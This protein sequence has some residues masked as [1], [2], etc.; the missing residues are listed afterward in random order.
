MRDSKGREAGQDK[1]GVQMDLHQALTSFALYE[2]CL[3]VKTGIADLWRVRDSQQRDLVLKLYHSDDMGNEAPGV[4]LMQI[5]AQANP[6]PVPHLYHV[7]RNAIVMDFIEAGTLGQAMRDGHWAAD[8]ALATFAADLHNVPL[9]PVV[10][11]P[12]LSEWF[13]VLFQITFAPDCPDGTKRD[14][15][16]A[17][18]LARGLLQSQSNIRPLHG[19]LHHDNVFC[20]DFGHVAID[21][22]GV[23]GEPAYE[24]ANAMRNPKGCAARLY[25]KDLQINRLDI[26]ARHLSVDRTRLAQWAAAKCAWSMAL[27]AKG[28]QKADPEADLLSLLLNLADEA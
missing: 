10:G 20:S 16:R 23:L 25:D 19:D 8:E 14:M 24:L 7:T 12:A 2:P 9:P 1:A 15:R 4:A 28:T 17:S 3:L 21:A 11:L 27:R 5:W 26:F 18:E 6:R 13:H 22:K